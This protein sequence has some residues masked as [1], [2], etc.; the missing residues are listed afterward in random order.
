M[1]YN[2]IT[3]SPRSSCTS[4]PINYKHERDPVIGKRVWNGI[5]K[6]PK[7]STW[8]IFKLKIMRG[9]MYENKRMIRSRTHFTNYDLHSH[10]GCISFHFIYIVFLYKLFR[11]HSFSPPNSSQNFFTSLPIQHPFSS[12][13]P[14]VPHS[15]KRK[16][17]R[18]ESNPR[19]KTNPTHKKA[20]TQKIWSKYCVFHLLLAMGS[21]LECGWYTQWHVIGG[22]KLIFPMSVI[23]F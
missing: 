2:L 11:W 5:K 17:K 9:E 6:G 4:F 13:F 21:T 23:D 10:P 16:R 19:Q 15:K 22:G 1:V 7:I 12:L 3:V 20:H 14:S 8:T 18:K